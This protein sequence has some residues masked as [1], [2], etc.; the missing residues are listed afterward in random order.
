MSRISPDEKSDGSFVIDGELVF[1]TVPDLLL[2]SRPLFE[3]PGATI[4]LD[5]HGVTRGDSAGLAL[6]VEW[7]RAARQGGKT[8]TFRNIPDQMIALA[9]VS[10]LDA[11]LQ[12][13]D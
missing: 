8:I 13:K 6:L 3:T 7:L 12:L 9:K 1:D 2:S 11:L 10:G 5:L 4:G